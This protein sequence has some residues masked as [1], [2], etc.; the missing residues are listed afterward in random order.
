MRARSRALLIAS[1][2]F[3]LAGAR[4]AVAQHST[5]ACRR[6]DP[7][8]TFTFTLDGSRYWDLRRPA[9]FRCSLHAGGPVRR[10]VLAGD[11][12]GAMP[13][14][15]RIGRPH[16]QTFQLGE[17]NTTL[18][19]GSPYLRA[20]DLNRDGWT[21][22]LVLLTTGVNGQEWYAVFLYAPGRGRF[23]EDPTISGGANIE[24]IAGRCVRSTENYLYLVTREE[25]CWRGGRWLRVRDQRLEVH[26]GGVEIRTRRT[27]HRGR[28]TEVVVD[29]PRAGG[30]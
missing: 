24:R 8:R 5:G 10:V 16:P 1:A 21:D 30:R 29:T 4:R 6:T 2:A 13:E 19:A 11:P 7:A 15:L 26:T 18:P 28:R 25:H 20:E 17:G 12:V 3:V 23:V 22:L 27:F 9:V 14:T